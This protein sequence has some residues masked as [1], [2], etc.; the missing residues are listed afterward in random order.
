MDG[1]ARADR[2]FKADRHGEWYP[3]IKRTR[4]SSARDTKAEQ[5]AVEKRYGA[6]P[7]LSP[8]NTQWET[9]PRLIA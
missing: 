7:A 8:S 4:L 3:I 1:D 6:C 5:P 9:V 2:G